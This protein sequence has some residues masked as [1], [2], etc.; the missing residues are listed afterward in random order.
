M[1]RSPDSVCDFSAENRSGENLCALKFVFPSTIQL[2][3]SF[4]VTGASRIPLR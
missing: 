2:Q 4:A 3:I 1:L